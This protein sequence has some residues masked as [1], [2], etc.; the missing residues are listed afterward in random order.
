[1]A[2]HASKRTVAEW[3]VYCHSQGYTDLTEC[4]PSG[5]STPGVFCAPLCGGD[6][7]PSDFRQGLLQPMCKEYC[8]HNEHNQA[9]LCGILLWGRA[10]KGMA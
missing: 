1:M 5:K 8:G 6:V 7:Y 4:D 9:A 2:S 10:A 3:V